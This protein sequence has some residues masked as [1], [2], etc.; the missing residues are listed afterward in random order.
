MYTIGIDM[1]TISRIQK[2]LEKESF[3]NH[4]Y[5][6]KELQ[7]FY[8]RDKIKYNSLAANFAAKEAFSKALGTGIRD[9]DL[10]EVQILREDSGKPYFEFSGKAADIMLKGGLQADVSLSHEGDTAIA[11]VIIYKNQEKLSDM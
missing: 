2:S 9:F 11:M 4:V 7:A 5:G 10:D 8:Y 1:T 3:A 6:E